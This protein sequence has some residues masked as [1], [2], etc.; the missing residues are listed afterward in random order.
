[1]TP[2][3]RWWPHLFNNLIGDL[4]EMHG[5]IE[6]QWPAGPEVDGASH[7]RDELAPSHRR[8]RGLRTQYGNGSL[9]PFEEVDLT[10]CQ[11]IRNAANVRLASCADIW[12]PILP[13]S[14]RRGA[15]GASYSNRSMLR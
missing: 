1:M 15:D 6:A 5:H 3:R 10:E 4:L 7:Q 8:P 14:A 12:Q 13:G 2:L 9:P 11:E